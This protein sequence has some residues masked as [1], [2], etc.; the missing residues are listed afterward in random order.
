MN[1]VLLGFPGAG[2]GTQA[3]K[4]RSVYGF[5]HISTGD[6]IRAEIA[7]KTPLG[8]EVKNLIEAGNLVSDEIIIKLLIKNIKDETKG[9]IFDGF[10][11]TLEQAKALDKYLSSIG[12]KADYVLLIELS[13]DEVLKRLTSRRVCRKCGAVYSVYD[14]GLK[15]ACLKC[16]GE[17]YTRSD[18]SL[19][20][21]KHRLEV[22][23]KETQPL[24]SY[25]EAAATGLK[26][27]NGSK[28]AEEVFKEI[29][30][31]LGLSK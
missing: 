19:E 8:L 22:F 1:I 16:G 23:K 9:I 20:S 7:A 3:D 12:Q 27:V 30:A 5:R 10:P 6:L 18:D 13:E 24:I 31:A 29:S 2:K 14:K 28:S 11:R 26:R 21:A 4:L 17:L 25:Y 15:D